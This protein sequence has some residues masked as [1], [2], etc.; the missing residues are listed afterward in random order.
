MQFLIVNWMR[1]PAF[2]ALG[3]MTQENLTLSVSL[4]PLAIASTWLGV[5]LVRRTS[6]PRFFLLIYALLVLVGAKLIWDG[7][8]TL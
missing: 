4:L 2:L 1:L 5:Q 3:R 8:G 7:W 6:G